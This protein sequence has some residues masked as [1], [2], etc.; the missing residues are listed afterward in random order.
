MK[1][2]WA[3]GLQALGM[4]SAQAAGAPAPTSPYECVIDVDQTVEL[5]GPSEARIQSVLVRRGDK[6]QAGQTL[7]LLETAV[8]QSAVEAA[9]YRAQMQGRI[10]TARA[11]VEFA[12]KK[13]ARVQGLHRQEY[14][15]SQ[16]RDEAEA[17]QRLAHSEL[18]EA[19]EGQELA[20]R[21]AQQA[22]DAL[23]RRSLRSPFNGVVVERRGHPGEL[24]DG[25]AARQP[26]LKL[27]RVDPLRVEAVLPLAL[28]GQ[29]K[30]GGNAT[31]L[32]EV[33]GGR[34]P[35][36]VTQVDSVI[37]AASGTFSVQLQLLNPQGRVPAGIR[38]KLELDRAG[39]GAV[40]P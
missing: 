31:V 18:R 5:R 19:T 34:H 17:E 3:A 24:A 38:C 23:A 11:R 27:A 33:L 16:Q 39:N 35:A 37:D 12:D 7:V 1:R 8:E 28:W 32:P 2:Y 22:R 25:G 9:A 40:R 36:K 26:I 10:D 29:V 14:A 13:L 15:T 6:V 4:A 30:V 21:E 20:R